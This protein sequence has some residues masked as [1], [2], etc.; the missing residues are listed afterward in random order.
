MFLVHIS[1]LGIYLSLCLNI[2]SNATSCRLVVCLQ[3]FFFLWIRKKSDK[4]CNSGCLHF[5]S[6]HHFHDRFRIIFPKSQITR[7]PTKAQKM[8]SRALNFIKKKKVDKCV[9]RLF[10]LGIL[11]IFINIK[12]QKVL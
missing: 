8:E 6:S 10:T 2:W 12:H 9:S 3:R 1:V 11:L 5:L 4:L 7:F